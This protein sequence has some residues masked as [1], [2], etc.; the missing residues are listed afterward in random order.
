MVKNIILTG[1]KGL[2]GIKLLDRLK[3]EEYNVNYTI[4]SRSGFNILNLNSLK[5]NNEEINLF[6]HTAAFCKIAESIE[7]PF[8]VFENNIRGTFEVLEFCRKNKIK[9]IMFFS[10]SRVSSKEENPYTVSKKFGELLCE[11]YNQCYGIEY[12]I[13]RPSTVYGTGFHDKTS[14]LI[15]EWIERALKHK[16][17]YIYGNKYKTLDFTYID[18]FID[19]VVLLIKNWDKVKNK[20]FN[21]SGNNEIQLMTLIKIIENEL[22]YEIKYRFKN[23]EI[24]QPQ[25]V[26]VDTSDM[27][28]LGYKPKVNI[29]QGIKRLI[30]WYKK[31]GK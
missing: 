28:V 25:N 6:I 3:K 5:I 23:P 19:G 4:D 29:F 12:V 22:G 9:K 15:T 30:R 18:D 20:S 10:S 24:A 27:K 21:I 7:E 11:A 1:H 31:N 16:T 14:R 13:V 8:L 17:L 26:H 2:I